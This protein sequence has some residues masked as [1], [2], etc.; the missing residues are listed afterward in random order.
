MNI[1]HLKPFIKTLCKIFLIGLLFQF[2]IQTFV[3]FQ[4][5]WDGSFRN[6]VRM[7]KEFILLLLCVAVGYASLLH[8][9]AFLKTPPQQKNLWEFLKKYPLTQ[10]AVLFVLTALLF[11][12]L[13]IGVQ[14]VGW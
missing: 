7:R 10:G 12:I 11:M 14:K 8:L 3:T 1:H 2:F 4:L 13:A 5:G 6:F 9:P